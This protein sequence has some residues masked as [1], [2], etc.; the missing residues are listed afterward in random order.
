MLSQRS[1]QARNL[2][3]V[4]YWAALVM[5]QGFAQMLIG[6]KGVVVNIGSLSGIVTIPFQSTCHLDS[7][8]KLSPD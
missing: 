3:E 1:F 4:N 7:R 6:A 8:A 2:F 5:V